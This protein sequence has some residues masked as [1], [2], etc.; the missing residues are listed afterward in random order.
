MKIFITV[1]NASARKNYVDK[2]EVELPASVT[3]LQLLVEEIVRQNVM[4]YNA[5]LEQGK[6]T[7]FLTANEMRDLEP[8]GKIG[9]GETYDNRQADM[10][11]AL[12]EAE[13]AFE[14]GLYRVFINE[15]E[16]MEY[17]QTIAMEQHDT[18]VFLRLTM[19]AGRMW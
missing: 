6:L 9:F 12:Q 17:K 18:V 14:D 3:T 8:T 10:E 11:K 7:A 4:H 1:K 13:A 5:S 16:I 19:L 2:L 15:L